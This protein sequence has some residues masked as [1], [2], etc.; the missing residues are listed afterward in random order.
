[1]IVKSREQFHNTESGNP[2][3]SKFFAIY[4]QFLLISIIFGQNKNKS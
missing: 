4:F 1:M 2:E 3:N